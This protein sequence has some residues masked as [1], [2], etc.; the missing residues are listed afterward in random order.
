MKAVMDRRCSCAG[1][2]SGKKYRAECKLRYPLR[3]STL[4][5][6]FYLLELINSYVIVMCML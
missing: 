6:C 5:V 1:N 2:R 4:H 3:K